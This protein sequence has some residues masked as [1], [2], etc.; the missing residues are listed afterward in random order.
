MIE[1]KD[2]TEDLNYRARTE[3]WKTHDVGKTA[4]SCHQTFL[5]LFCLQEDYKRSVLKTLIEKPFAWIYPMAEDITIFV[6][7][8]CARTETFS[9]YKENCL[10]CFTLLSWI[11]PWPLMFPLFIRFTTGKNKVNEFVTASY[12]PNCA[13]S[14]QIR[15]WQCFFQ[16]TYTDDGT[17][18]SANN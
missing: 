16:K 11:K 1:R 3:I 14:G 5:H 10:G 2:V 18:I 15:K 17:G 12:K 4:I 6:C 8:R 7:W 9:S 13:K